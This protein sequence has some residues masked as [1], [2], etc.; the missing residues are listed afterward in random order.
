MSKGDNMRKFFASLALV[1][2]LALPFSTFTACTTAQSQSASNVE[3]QTI[4]GL[5]NTVSV[6]RGAYD[7]LYKAG[8]ISADLDA[9]VAPIYAQYQ[10]V[11]DAAIATAKLQIGVTTSTPN[12]FLPQLEDLVNQL[13]AL[14]GQG[15]GVP[16]AK[17]TISRKAG[18]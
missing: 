16:V 8:K 9:K 10:A 15:S 5:V 4:S 2:V 1:A 12:Q 17:V 11:A 7:A 6:A 14:F 18:L 3:Y 13:F